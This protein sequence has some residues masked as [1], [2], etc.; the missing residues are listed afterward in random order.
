MLVINVLISVIP[1]ILLY[2]SFNSV[3]GLDLDTPAMPQ[4]SFGN[5]L[6]ARQFGLSAGCG[7]RF[8]AFGQVAPFTASG[9]ANLCLQCRFNAF[10]IFS[11]DFT[12]F[13]QLSSSISSRGV[14]ASDA[15]IL[16]SH[17]QSDLDQKAAQ[18]ST[19]AQCKATFANDQRCSSSS[20]V[21][22]KC[23]ATAIDC[24]RN[25]KNGPVLAQVFQSI[26]RSGGAPFCSI[27]SRD[28]S[29]TNPSARAARRSL[30]DP[31]TN[32]PRCPAGLTAC[33][34]SNVQT[35]KQSTPFECLDT[36]QEIT[37]CGGCATLGQGVDC[38][39]LRGVRLSGC[40]KGECT[41]FSCAKGYELSKQENKCRRR[42]LSKNL[43]P[44][45]KNQ[46]PVS[47]FH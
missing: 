38:S 8:N 47:A 28:K 10:G 41:I 1:L 39:A 26:F 17:I 46:K 30:R 40:S 16:Q 33:P 43:K 2:A 23:K 12:F 9:N 32:E 22:G 13:N 24:V 14:S 20:F 27:C 4:S 45:F 18:Q 11:L 5:Q 7:L 37:S 29:C 36:M 25:N 34:I 6:V 15:S 31:K 3:G 21:N 35:L 44:G 42:Q 19:S